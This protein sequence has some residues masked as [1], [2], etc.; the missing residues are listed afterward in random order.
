MSRER[1]KKKPSYEDEDDERLKNKIA[2][3]GGMFVKRCVDH[4]VYKLSC[5]YETAMGIGS[6]KVYIKRIPRKEQH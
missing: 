1:T 5:V 4:G 3:M 2:V 6:L